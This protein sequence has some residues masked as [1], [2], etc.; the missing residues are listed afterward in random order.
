MDGEEG[1]ARVEAG[2]LLP[3]PLFLRWV[4]A[5]E[6][7]EGDGGRRPDGRGAEGGG[8]EELRRVGRRRRA[9]LRLMLLFIYLFG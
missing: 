4:D 3:Y 2:A 7:G 8:T 9:L 6:E 5:W 1:R